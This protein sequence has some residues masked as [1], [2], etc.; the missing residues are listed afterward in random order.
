MSKE[1]AAQGLVQLPGTRIRRGDRPP[2]A[3]GGAGAGQALAAREATG[4]LSRE[5][6]RHCG[7]GG[8]ADAALAA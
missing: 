4:G 1:P 5:H 3:C 6:G 2:G 8:A 7:A